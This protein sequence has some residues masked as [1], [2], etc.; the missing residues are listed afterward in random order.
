MKIELDIPQEY[1]LALP[2]EKWEEILLR[3]IKLYALEVFHYRDMQH[4]LVSGGKLFN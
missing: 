2:R 1:E 4:K 3:Y